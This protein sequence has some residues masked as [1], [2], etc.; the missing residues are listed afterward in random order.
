MPAIRL[1]AVDLD[2]TL[3][4]SA[5]TLAPGGVAALR[6]AAERGVWVVVATARALD[7]AAPLCTVLGVRDPLICY[8]GA[9][10]YACWDGP[11][12]EERGLPP[13]LAADLAEEADRRGWTLRLAIAGRRAGA[14]QP[15]ACPRA[16]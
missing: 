1:I 2:G 16:A 15:A 6:R 9:Q 7:S 11:L 10:T 5:R 3:L 4:T 12:W 13:D 8:S 14:G